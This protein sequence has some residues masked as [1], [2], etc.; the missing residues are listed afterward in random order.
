MPI[1]TGSTSGGGTEDTAKRYMIYGDSTTPTLYWENADLAW[2][3]EGQV[4]LGSYT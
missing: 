3:P 2:M 4:D 1:L